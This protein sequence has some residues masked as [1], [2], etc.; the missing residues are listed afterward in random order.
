MIL[1]KM[2]QSAEARSA[3]RAALAADPNHPL[4]RE[5]LARLDDKTPSA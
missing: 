5:A 3:Y 1:E 2:G 4:A